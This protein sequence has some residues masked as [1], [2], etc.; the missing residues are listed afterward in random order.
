MRLS[1][2]L[3][4]DS[5][6]LMGWIKD[7]PISRNDSIGFLSFSYLT[8]DASE[9]LKW[10]TSIGMVELVNDFYV[11]TAGSAHFFESNVETPRYKIYRNMLEKY[12]CSCSPVWAARIPFGRKEVYFFLNEDEQRCFIEARLMNEYDKETVKWWDEVSAFVRKSHDIKLSEEGREGEYLSIEYEHKRTGMVPR[13]VSLDSNLLGYDIE[14]IVSSENE[15]RLLIEVKTTVL[16]DNEA[17]I[18][19]SENEWS[20]ASTNA[21]YLFHIWNIQTSVPKLM[22]VTAKDIEGNIPQNLGEGN[23]VSVKIRIQKLINEKGWKENP[24]C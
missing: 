23:W 1:S 10:L 19:L 6:K 24:I 4:Y 16:E 20:V 7:K 22:I 9:I 18:Y 2:K 14:S 8:I 12:I 3:L 13:L 15:D 11:L 5:V 17:T 21:N